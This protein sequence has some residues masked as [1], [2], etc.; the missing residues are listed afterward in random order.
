MKDDE[1][2]LCDFCG[3]MPL[4]VICQHWAPLV[5]ARSRPTPI[6]VRHAGTLA[7]RRERPPLVHEIAAGVLITIGVVLGMILL[8]V[9]SSGTRR[10][11]DVDGAP[12]SCQQEVTSVPNDQV[13]RTVDLGR[14]RLRR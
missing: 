4:D 6:L 14:V 7:R 12:T 11:S 9:F 3:A 8:T 1:I 2:R 5:L 13:H 10:A